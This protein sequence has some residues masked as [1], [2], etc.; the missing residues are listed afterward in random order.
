MMMHFCAALE[1]ADGISRF[2]P[3][4]DIPFAVDSV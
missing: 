3:G 1:T 2:R 4:D